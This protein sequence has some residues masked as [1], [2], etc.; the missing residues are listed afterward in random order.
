MNESHRPFESLIKALY[1][2]EKDARVYY[3]KA[4]NFTY[5]LLM[6]FSLFLAFSLAGEMNTELIVAGLPALAVMFGTS[7]IE[8]VAIVLEKQT[9]TFERLLTAPISFFTL[10]GGKT[11][12]G[13]FFGVVIGNLVIIPLALVSGTSIG[14][15]VMVFAA[16]A[17][18]SFVFSALGVL[19]SAYAD[20][21]PE[22]QM[23]SNL[24][25]FPMTFLAGTFVP[26]ELMP[27]QLQIVARFLPLTYSVEAIRIGISEPTAF[28]TYFTDI[29][30]LALFSIILLFLAARILQRK[31][32]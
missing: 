8:A 13:L 14:S 18:S 15:P 19:V 17:L 22:A 32:G 9:G 28:H 20:W 1:I 26:F 30:A 29:F 6:P 5:G 31:L 24:I 3:F 4:P 2:A 23:F 11:L 16:I 21:V 25:R 12:S 10:L 27:A 7:S